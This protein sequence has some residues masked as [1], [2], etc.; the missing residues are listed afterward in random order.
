MQ[1]QL[2]NLEKFAKIIF[3]PLDI[4]KIFEAARRSSGNPF[5]RHHRKFGN[6]FFFHF[7]F[8]LVQ[9]RATVSLVNTWCELKDKIATELGCNQK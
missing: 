9:K 3:F 7:Y 5:G 4:L 2:Y 8:K 6:I 1:F